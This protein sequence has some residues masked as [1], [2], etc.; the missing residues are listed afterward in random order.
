MSA[1]L[2]QYLALL[3]GRPLPQQPLARVRALAREIAEGALR[4]LW[5]STINM[6]PVQYATID[7]SSQLVLSA[8]HGNGGE[9]DAVSL[10]P[11]DLTLQSYW[12]RRWGTYK[13]APA[14][15]L[16]VT[17]GY[18]VPGN[19]SRFHI[20]FTI[21]KAAYDLID[22]AEAAQV[23]VSYRR[24]ESS[25]FALLVLARLK[26]AGI[27]AYVDL[28]MSPG[29]NYLDHLRQQIFSRDYFIILL[30]P[31]TLESPEV[32]QELIW[33]NEA[34]ATLI[35]IWHN[36]FKYPSRKDVPI[37]PELDQA[38]RTTHTIRVLEESALGYNTA[39]V[40]LLNRFGISPD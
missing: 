13:G 29:D 16:L 10:I 12:A 17:N 3:A 25:A 37:P 14:L 11:G 33:A 36:G 1:E 40:E 8:D 9:T 6:V 7:E 30:G 34:G 39:M 32:L 27:H 23:F 38:L 21:T 28:A 5:T 19:S 35:P 4:R 24:R 2:D 22:E 31:T 26:A 15:D 20:E 18:L